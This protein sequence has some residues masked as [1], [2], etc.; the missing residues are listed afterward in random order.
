MQCAGGGDA[1]YICSE[2]MAAALHACGQAPG[3][4]HVR[5][6]INSPGQQVKGLDRGGALDKGAGGLR[7]QPTELPHSAKRD[8]INSGGRPHSERAAGPR[9]KATRAK[10]ARRSRDPVARRDIR[11]MLR[12]QRVRGAS[13]APARLR[14]SVKGLSCP[15]AHLHCQNLTLD[16][17]AAMIAGCCIGFVKVIHVRLLDPT[18]PHSDAPG[19]RCVVILHA[20]VLSM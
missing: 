5:G 16:L 8:V 13:L 1:P 3:T 18:S 14:A 15:L 20:Y 12:L 19:H 2:S 9:M 10:I 6:S 4:S 11:Q 7:G 17:S